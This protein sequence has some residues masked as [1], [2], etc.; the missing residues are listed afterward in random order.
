MRTRS[1][2]S[3]HE[4]ETTFYFSARDFLLSGPWALRRS[5][6]THSQPSLLLVN[7]QTGEAFGPDDAIQ[8]V[9]DSKKVQSA[10]TLMV[11]LIKSLPLDRQ[12]ELRQF[13]IL[14][15]AAPIP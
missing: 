12:A 5:D 7:W 13:L 10:S 11:H 2:S 1:Q 14:T 3:A 15:H 9:G 8:I 6:S 4:H